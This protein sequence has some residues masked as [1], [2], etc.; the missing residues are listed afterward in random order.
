MTML[1]DSIENG[2][3]VAAKVASVKL[4]GGDWRKLALTAIALL[5]SCMFGVYQLMAF[6]ARSEVQR[7][8]TK[9]AE[10]STRVEAIDA[11]VKHLEDVQADV[12]VLKN[13]VGWIRREMER[14]AH[15]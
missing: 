11:R 10:F 4:D 5:V 15:K 3:E 13:D 1:D 9:D 14:Q 2:A 12:A 6:V 7:L 8:D